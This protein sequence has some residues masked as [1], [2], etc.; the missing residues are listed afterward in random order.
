LPAG[1]SI[2][3]S[4]AKQQAMTQLRYPAEDAPYELERLKRFGLE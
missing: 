1:E 4:L 3:W 2:V